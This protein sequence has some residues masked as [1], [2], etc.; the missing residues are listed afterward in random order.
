MFL[1]GRWIVRRLNKLLAKILEKRHVEASLS[2]F[3]KS[4]VNI[5]LTL[6]LIIV[7]IG[8][9]GIETSSFIALFGTCR[10]CHWYGI[11]R[12]VTEFRRRG[13][14]FVVQAV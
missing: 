2:T 6:L 1:V 12:Y 7:V 9:L 5:T 13:N 4:L 3:V 10:C 8:V 11:E 14:D